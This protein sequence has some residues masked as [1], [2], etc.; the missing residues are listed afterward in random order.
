M[1][2]RHIGVARTLSFALA[3]AA[4]ITMTSGGSANAG[5]DA[6]NHV[7]DKNGTDISVSLVDTA[8]NFVA[9]LDDS[10]LTREWYHDGR[11]KISISGEKA[12][13]F[14]GT[15]I[16]GYQVGYPATFTGQLTFSWLSPNV[17]MNMGVG[18]PPT[19]TAT[20]GIPSLGANLSVGNGPGV[21]DVE[22][23]RTA[24]TGCDNEMAV[25]AFHGSLT[26]VIGRTNIRP[27]V[28]VISDNGFRVTTVGPIFRA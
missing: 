22:A 28:T 12:K 18:T 9:P 2:R 10:F 15:V 3:A 14:K 4:A 11:A 13:D 5:I 19:A 20:L 25:M 26:G 7:L 1:I 27:W 24:I 17:S 23:I 21:V 8:I 6:T 16:M